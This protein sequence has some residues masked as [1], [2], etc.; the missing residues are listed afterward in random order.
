MNDNLRMKIDVFPSSKRKQKLRI[1]LEEF[2]KTFLHRI[3]VNE[4]LKL[5]K[6]LISESLDGLNYIATSNPQRSI[7]QRF[8]CKLVDSGGTKWSHPIAKTIPIY[9]KL[10]ITKAAIKLSNYLKTQEFM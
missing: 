4:K 1:P 6:C 7:F 10:L 3:S 2:L 9:D 8:T 5:F